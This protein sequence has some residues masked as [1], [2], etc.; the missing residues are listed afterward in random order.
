MFDRDSLTSMGIAGAVLAV[1]VVAYFLLHGGGEVQPLSD[2]SIEEEPAIEEPAAPTEATEAPPTPTEVTATSPVEAGPQYVFP[3]QPESAASYARGH[4]GFP[5]TDIYAPVGTDF[6]AVTAGVV[7]EVQKRDLWN[8]AGGNTDP[9]LRNGIYIAYIGDDGVRYF[10]SHLS[11]IAPGIRAGARVEAGQLLGA[12][13][14][15]G[16]AKPGPSYVHFGVSHPTFPG[17]WEVRRGEVDTY[18]YLRAWQRGRDV[19]PKVP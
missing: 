18:P 10:G 2:A 5:A 15:T 19:T 11:M 1:A 9:N 4:E 7:D 17:D 16:K 6:V 3:V 14:K 12:V 13:G 8:P